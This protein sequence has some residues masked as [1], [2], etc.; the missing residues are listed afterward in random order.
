MRNYCCSNYIFEEYAIRK[1]IDKFITM[2][3]ILYGYAKKL[4]SPPTIVGKDIVGYKWSL[5]QILF[6]SDKV[7]DI[8]AY[9]KLPMFQKWD[10]LKYEVDCNEK[11]EE[12]IKIL[13]IIPR[14]KAGKKEIK[15]E[16][17]K[18]ELL[19]EFRATWIN[20]G[21]DL[22]LYGVERFE[23]V[24]WL[25]R[26]WK[27]LWKTMNGNIMMEE[28]VVLAKEL[29]FDLHGEIQEYVITKS[30]QAEY[31]PWDGLENT[32]KMIRRHKRSDDEYLRIANKRKAEKEKIKTE[33]LNELLEKW[34]KNALDLR[35]FGVAGFEDTFGKIKIGTILWKTID[36][37][38][39][40][41]KD[42]DDLAEA[43]W[44]D[45]KEEIRNLINKTANI[46]S[47][48]GLIK[49]GIV[50]FIKTFGSRIMSFVA[51]DRKQKKN[52]R[53]LMAFW[54]KL[55]RS[56]KTELKQSLKNNKITNGL[57]LMQVHR[58]ILYAQKWYRWPALNRSFNTIDLKER[59][60]ILEYL[61]W[62][63]VQEIVDVIG[64]CKN[65]LN[66]F[67]KL[68]LWKKTLPVIYHYK[69]Q[70]EARLWY[71]LEELMLEK[72]NEILQSKFKIW[73]DKEYFDF[74]ARQLRT[75]GLQNIGFVLWRQ[76]N[77][78]TYWEK[79][80][81]GKLTWYYQKNLQKAAL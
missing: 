46:E 78:I 59:F 40:S 21:L 1:F 33:L 18:C 49:Y 31:N 2:T 56:L 68:K 57:Q 50:P 4:D 24:F 54:E 48:I 38:G 74:P 5:Y 65:P 79:L 13:S 75:F 60:D 71:P 34:I 35:Y 3:D 6:C 43:L 70:V 19:E 16:Q 27:I 26:I 80:D 64:E 10:V 17:Y 67:T 11:W 66:V 63:I 61:W 77:D 47:Q 7:E 29:W 51:D 14:L 72:I 44:R 25:A 30:L 9:R 53:D 39:I 28:L 12:L 41:T 81:L 55:W 20:S 23:S 45:I 15:R 22:V 58:K 36:G 42:L 69:K 62:D 76:V 8:Y 52:L 73:S 37:W 32:V